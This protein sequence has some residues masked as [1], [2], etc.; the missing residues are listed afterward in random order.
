MTIE[1]EHRMQLRVPKELWLLF[2]QKI[3]AGYRSE[4]MRML[5][6]LFLEEMQDKGLKA[7][8]HLLAG[9]YKL[10]LKEDTKHGY[11]SYE[12]RRSEGAG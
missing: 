4:I 9:E 11:D 5:L 6:G 12:P 1:H 8:G 3:P 7:F 2:K 10:A